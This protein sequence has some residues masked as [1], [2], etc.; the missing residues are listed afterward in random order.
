MSAR[1]W[2][3]L[4]LLWL[5]AGAGCGS[6]DPGAPGLTGSDDWA[7]CPPGFQD[8]CRTMMM[9]LD[10]AAP[11]GAQIPVF[12]SRARSRAAHRG[13]VWLLAGGPGQ[14]A[15]AF[16][17]F[18]DSLRARVPGLDVYTIEHRGV[19]QSARLACAEQE[20]PSSERGSSITPAEVPACVADAQAHANGGLAHFRLTPAARDLAEAIDRTRTPGLD[21]FVYGVSYGTEWAIRYMQLR[22]N[23]A[24]GIVLDSVS[25]PGFNPFSRA[26]ERYDPVLKKLA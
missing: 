14:S 1:G 20:S 22:P 17:G 8:E 4:A 23:D 18:I 2:R 11:A 25:G 24:T 26:S 13:G 15:D 12:V 7:P 3:C 21:V 19:G 9:P 16:E 5:G 10:W 6:D